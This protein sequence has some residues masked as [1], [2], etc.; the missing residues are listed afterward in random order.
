MRVEVH[1]LG[2]LTWMLG[3]GS[4]SEVLLKTLT[5]ECQLLLVLLVLTLSVELLLVFYNFYE[6]LVMI[7]FQSQTMMML[8]YR[9]FLISLMQM[10]LMFRLTS[11]FQFLSSSQDI[12]FWV[13]R[14]LE[15]TCV[16]ILLKFYRKFWELR[17][18]AAA[19]R[20][21][22]SLETMFMRVSILFS[23]WRPNF[24]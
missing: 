15:S 14:E 21:L 22:T 23:L 1:L 13:C 7:F 18:E 5:P 16:L 17:S 10:G 24:F 11:Q 8:L 12:S 9:P 4:D 6:G 2:W 19:K 20:L 3:L